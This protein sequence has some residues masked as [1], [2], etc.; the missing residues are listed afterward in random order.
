MQL[1]QQSFLTSISLSYEG[2]EYYVLS[3]KIRRHSSI[4][5]RYATLFSA[6]ITLTNSFP[7]QQPILKLWLKAQKRCRRILISQ[8]NMTTNSPDVA[9]IDDKLAYHIEMERAANTAGDFTK[10]GHHRKMQEILGAM[11]QMQMSP[12]Q[13]SDEDYRAPTSADEEQLKE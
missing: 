13:I 4:L 8:D 2:F 12:E 1:L 9:T 11:K 10:A 7:I 6:V 5:A 3:M